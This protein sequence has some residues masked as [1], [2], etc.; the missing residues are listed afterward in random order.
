MINRLVAAGVERV[1]HHYD[2][3]LSAWGKITS[4]APRRPIRAWNIA[5]RDHPTVVKTLNHAVQKFFVVA[6][7]ITAPLRSDHVTGVA[8]QM[9]SALFVRNCMIY[10]IVLPSEEKLP[11]PER[12]QR[13][14]SRLRLTEPAAYL[15]VYPIMRARELFYDHRLRFDR[16]VRIMH[17]GQPICGFTQFSKHRSALLAMAWSI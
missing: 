2:S 17:H 4:L 3:V 8:S 5:H 7:D 15:Y 11:D 10:D 12:V 14:M 9:L 16:M 6:D 1:D 13:V